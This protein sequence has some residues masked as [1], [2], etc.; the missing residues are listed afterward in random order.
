MKWLIKKLLRETYL[1]FGPIEPPKKIVNEE[2]AVNDIT[3]TLYRGLINLD[4]NSQHNPELVID[5]NNYKLSVDKYPDKLIWFTDNDNFAENYNGW[6]LITY[7][8]P[9]KK[10]V[11][12]VTYEDGS[13]RDYAITEQIES[14]YNR[15]IIEPEPH[16]N[17][18][19]YRGIELPDHWFWSY[20]TQKHIVCDTD[21]I[22]T[23]NNLKINNN[24]TPI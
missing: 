11:K 22:I 13:K 23:K 5:G 4:D 2:I 8:L 14:A 9:A 6:G 12:I 3:L 19:L 24:K 17:N 21:L 16:E 7:K 1:D 20:K 10:H 15:G 18:H